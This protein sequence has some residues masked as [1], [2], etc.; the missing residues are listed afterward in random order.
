MKYIFII[1][2][3]T[4]LFSCNS[5]NP[6]KEKQETSDTIVS[7][8]NPIDTFYFRN[9]QNSKVVF[10]FT[11]DTNDYSRLF[12][13]TTKT[14]CFLKL[15]SNQMRSIISPILN[16]ESNYVVE[17]MYGHLISSQDKIYDYKPII[18]FVNG[19]DYGALLYILLDNGNKPV[20]HFVMHGGFCGGDYQLND[21]TQGHCPII[22]STIS[23]DIINSYTLKYFDKLDTITRPSVI[24]SISYLIKIKENGKLET[25]KIDSV[26]FSR[27]MRDRRN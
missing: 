12:S 24:D 4:T 5:N 1:S 7:T 17:Y 2:L 15:D 3:L 20:S 10:N 18:V 27:I 9:I 6:E 25:K 8:I 22:H 13:D 21:S 23:K 26:R 19:D 16:L 14:K 11:W